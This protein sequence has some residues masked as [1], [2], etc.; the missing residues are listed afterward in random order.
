MKIGRKREARRGGFLKQRKTPFMT[1]FRLLK[2]A[3][4]FV[5]KRRSV[6]SLNLYP[7]SYPKETS[8]NGSPQPHPEPHGRATFDFEINKYYTIR[9]SMR[10][11]NTIADPSS[12]RSPPT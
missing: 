11:N 6:V 4:A 2:L 8:E 1:R 3:V 7:Y 5:S 9:P 12:P 10:I